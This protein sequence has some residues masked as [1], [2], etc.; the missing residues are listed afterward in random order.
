MKWEYKAATIEGDKAVP[1]SER[2][3]ELGERGWELIQVALD[4]NLFVFKRPKSETFTE[5]ERKM[6]DYFRGTVDR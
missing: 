1:L 3:N 4:S 6:V 2:L 5:D